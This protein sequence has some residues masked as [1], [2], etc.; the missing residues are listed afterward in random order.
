MVD[1]SPDHELDRSPARVGEADPRPGADARRQG[2]A[3][4]RVLDVSSLDDP[5]DVLLARDAQHHTARLGRGRRHGRHA[6]RG[7]RDE[8]ERECEYQVPHGKRLRRESSVGRGDRPHAEWIIDR[9]GQA[10]RA[11]FRARSLPAGPYSAASCRRSRPSI[12]HAICD[13]ARM[14]SSRSRSSSCSSTS[15]TSSRSHSCRTSCSSDLSRA[16]AG[17][18]AFLLLVVWW[19]WIYTTWMVNWFDPDSAPVRRVLL[20]VMRASLVHRGRAARGVRRPRR[21]LRARLRRAPGRAQCDGG[22]AP[23]ARAHPAAHARA[24]RGLEPR[25]GRAL[26]RRRLLESATAASTGGFPRSRSSCSP[27]SSAMPRRCADDRAPATTTSRVGIS[28][29][30]VRGSS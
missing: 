19:A 11:P 5:Q 12:A 22:C 29:S 7:G 23:P 17:R 2:P 16:G 28:P 18:A 25:V 15:C 6:G 20:G 27:P 14:A 21:S 1:T 13:R 30:A 26:G 3:I 24:H 9:S 10:P 8:R 4:G